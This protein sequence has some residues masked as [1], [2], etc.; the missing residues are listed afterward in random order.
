[1]ALRQIGIRGY[2]GEAVVKEWLDEK[3]PK[4]KGYKI[5]YQIMPEDV[6]K[7]GGG[8]LDFA[9]VNEDIVNS[10]YEVKT[11][12]YILDKSFHIN[13]ALMFMWNNKGKKIKMITQDK[14][15]YTS[16][17]DTKSYLILLVPPNNDGINNIGLNNLNNILLFEEIFEELG[18]SLDKA[19]IRIELI[20]DLEKEIENLKNPTQGKTLRDDFIKKR[21]IA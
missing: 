2:V 1:M 16:D 15:K 4:S 21:N 13:D 19:K 5:V 12:D 18:D 10:I 3:F 17:V 6:P 7:K 14:E 11:Q 9:V 8:Y 20:D